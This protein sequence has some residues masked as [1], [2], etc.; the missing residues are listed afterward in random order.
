MIRAQR[1]WLRVC[2]ERM[3]GASDATEVRR[4]TAKSTKKNSMLCAEVVSWCNER[5]SD[6]TRGSE[7]ARASVREDDMEERR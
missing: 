2:K 7:M 6:G 4:A 3:S 5:R 1:V